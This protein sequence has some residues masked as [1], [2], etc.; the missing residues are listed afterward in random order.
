VILPLKYPGSFRKRLMFANE[1]HCE[2]PSLRGCDLFIVCEDL[3]GVN[4]KNI[5]NNA[6][7]AV[8]FIARH[9]AIKLGA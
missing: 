3:A 6:N 8:R 7:R 4:A 5:R 9:P 1:C 2:R